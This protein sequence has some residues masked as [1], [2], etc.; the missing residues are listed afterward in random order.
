MS[1]VLKINL[2]HD[3]GHAR[4]SE[5]EYP[6]MMLDHKITEEEWGQAVNT[7]LTYFAQ[8][9]LYYV[10]VDLEKR[11]KSVGPAREMTIEEI[12]N[13]LGYKVKIVKEKE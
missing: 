4:I 11:N 10:I 6:N 13:E 3:F 8:K 5:D 1:K 12:E 9:E 7:V 2:E